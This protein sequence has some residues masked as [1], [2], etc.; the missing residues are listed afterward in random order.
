MSQNGLDR[1]SFLRNAGLTALAGAAAATGAPAVAAAAGATFEPPPNGK[2]D[3]DTIY[4]RFGTDSTK[5]DQQIRVYGKD[6]VQVGMGIADMDFRAAPAI[7][8]ALTERMQHENWGYLDM[9]GAFMKAHAESIVDWNKRRYNIDINPDSLVMTS[10]VHPAIIATLK[11]F[12]P[13]GSKV[14][15]QTPTYNGF[16]SDLTAAF[17]KAEESPLKL[18]NGRF[19]IDFEDLER[20]ISHDTNTL[21]LCNPQNPTGN[22]WSKEDLLRLGEICTRRRVIVLADEIHCDF[23]NKGQ[24]YTPYGTLGNKDIVMNSITFK[25][26]SKSFGLAAMKHAWMYSDNVDLLNRVKA[27][28]R[29][30][31]PTTTRN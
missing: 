23:V 16:Y 4:N 20:R 7:T 14:L 22:C 21:I 27:H 24:K 31:I 3:F 5:F 17:V 11:T 19:S 13:P 18:V 26:A 10:G 25:A 8:K 30:E 2:Y 28:H 29:A 9:Q 12:S 1:R 6:S 15:L